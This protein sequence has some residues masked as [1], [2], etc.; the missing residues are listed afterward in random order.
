ML[1]SFR[2]PNYVNISKHFEPVS[3]AGP[4]TG[5]T[6]WWP[7]EQYHQLHCFYWTLLNTLNL[8]WT[9]KIPALWR[10]SHTYLPSRRCSKASCCRHKGTSQPHWLSWL[11]FAQQ[12][13]NIVL[14][15]CFA[16]QVKKVLNTK[17]CLPGSNIDTRK[18]HDNS[19]NCYTSQERSNSEVLISLKLIRT[20][21][22]Y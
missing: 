5:S 6:A 11:G 10:K 4:P 14:N 9:D 16:P 22:I 21:T 1:A 2:V 7:W 13:S 19:T 17:I 3:L 8:Q 18:L 20:Q 15:L 12:F